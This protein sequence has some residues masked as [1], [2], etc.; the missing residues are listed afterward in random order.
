MATPTSTTI[1][2]PQAAADRWTRNSVLVLITC[3]LAWAFD[4]YEQTIL[5][6]VTPLL[7]Q[8]WNI[9]PATI[10][11]ITTV[12]RWVGLIGIF[13][14]PALADVYGRRPILILSILSYS[15]LTGITGFVQNWQQLLM[16]TSV[17]RIALSGEQPVGT[18]MVAETAPTKWR[19]TALGGLIGGYPFGYMLTSLAGLVVVPLWGWRALYWL[20]IVPA[21]LVF[22]VRMGVKESPRF[23]RVTAE[24]LKEGLK[25]QLDILAPARHYPRQMVLATVLYFCYLFTWIGWSAWMPQFLA[26]EKQLGFQTTATYLAIWMFAAIFAYWFCGF[27]CDRFG[28]RYV[29]PAFV[30]PAAILLVVLGGQN[31]PVGLFVVG[32]LANFLITGSFGSGL[33]YISELFPTVIRGTAYGSAA[34]FGGVG[35]ALAP[36]II[37]W[38]AT[39]HSIAAGLPLLAAVF[40]LLGPLFLW[41][42]PETTNQELTDFI[43]QK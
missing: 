24:M 12:A 8:E 5:Q 29:I 15:L 41:F 43:G 21:L 20:G 31:D 40:F 42:A 25:R 19:A 9:P 32:A 23:E 28:R 39:V 27:L 10:G 37:G 30:I 33:G 14:F 13:V 34:F 2:Q 35:A 7:I 3:I 22:F 36:A 11:L 18:V 16:A 4:I 38:I 17:T 6:L 1:D 26:N